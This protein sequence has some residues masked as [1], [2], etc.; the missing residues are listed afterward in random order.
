MTNGR[1]LRI[2]KYLPADETI[3]RGRYVLEASNIPRINCPARDFEFPEFV[4]SMREVSRICA[5]HW[6]LTVS[7]ANGIAMPTVGAGVYVEGEARGGGY[8]PLSTC[9]C[10]RMKER[11]REGVIAVREGTAEG[12]RRGRM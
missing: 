4:S 3:A 9:V 7:G 8:A 11:Q 12:E 1:V 6:S 10:E 2:A 5:F